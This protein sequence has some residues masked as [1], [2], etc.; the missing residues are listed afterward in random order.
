MKVIII[1]NGNICDF[2]L[3]KEHIQN[4]DIVICCDGGA[5]YAFDNAIMPNY[6]IGDLD[7]CI[8]QIIQFFETN[9][10]KIKKFNKE[11]DE[12][13]MELAINFAIDMKPSQILIFGAIGTRF[14]H[15]LANVNI[16]V[17]PMLAGIFTKIINENNEIFLINDEIKIENCKDQIVSLLPLT[18]EVKNICTN[19]LKY[20]LKN[21]TLTIGKSLGVSNII[22]NDI[23]Y[24]KIETGYLLVIKAKD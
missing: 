2:N 14:D 15:S 18:S 6:I 4:L 17:K 22:L 5:R 13:D 23:A 12:T 16:L 1:G 24:I 10:V 3:V 9:G 7:S 11:K 8:P 21:K 19:G 20:E